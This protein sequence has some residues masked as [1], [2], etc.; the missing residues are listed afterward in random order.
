M[1]SLLRRE[2]LIAVSVFLMTALLFISL[3][4]FATS[5][6][7][8]IDSTGT[9][10]AATS[11]PWGTF[12]VDQTSGKSNLYPVFAVG[13]DGTNTPAIFVSQKGVVSFGSST[14]SNLFLNVGDVVIGRNGA[15]SDL[16]VSGGLG[17]GNATTTDNGFV[18]GADIFTVYANSNI[19]MFGTSSPII[20]DGLSLGGSGTNADLFVSGG[21]GV[22]NAT[23]TDSGFV[24]GADVL[25]VF[26]NGTMGMFGTTSPVVIDGLSL[27]GA[28]GTHAD[29]YV[30]GGLG[31]GNATTTD[32]AL[33][34][35]NALRVYGSGDVLVGATSTAPGTSGFAVN[36]TDIMFSSNA[37]STTTVTIMNNSTTK[38]GC[39]E[40]TDSS[41]VLWKLFVATDS[42][43]TSLY[44]QPG[45]CQ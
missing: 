29:A 9:L 4:V 2:I 44:V 6:G 1:L 14:P 33:E 41:G 34:V 18:I 20:I 25:T 13:D 28:A 26:A 11:T 32:G 3:S 7:T 8:N 40:M 22:G 15:S 37:D 39:I 16:F 36:K 23:T 17:V 43:S 12:A 42:A 21:L 5:I 31:V 38:G 35:G 30:S 27:G 19:G 45:T 10:G 24:V